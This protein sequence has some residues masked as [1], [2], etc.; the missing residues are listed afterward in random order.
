MKHYEKYIISPSVGSNQGLVK[1]ECIWSAILVK[2]PTVSQLNLNRINAGNRFLEL[3]K[4][5]LCRILVLYSCV[6]DLVI[7]T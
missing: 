2:I 3:S 1:I 4:I 5:K 6:V 7:H